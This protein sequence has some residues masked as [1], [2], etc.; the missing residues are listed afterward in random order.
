MTV[1]PRWP[2][3]AGGRRPDGARGFTLIE[4]IVAL[5]IL[6]VAVVASIQGFAQGLRLLKLAGEHQHAT[7]LADQKL[8][9][10][11]SPKAGREEGRDEHGGHTFT[12][13][14]TTTEV[15]A[16]D[17]AG[18]GSRAPTW[19]AVQIAVKVRWAEHREVEL[20][21][22]RTTFIAG[23]TGVPASPSTPAA[24]TGTTPRAR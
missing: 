1:G 16:P 23:E 11:V 19:R 4:V 6:S 7:L 22:L 14:T 17:L 12:W 24:R 15:E 13:E 21:T 18:D 3:R 10:I 20:T 5:A 9:E 2:C 8:R